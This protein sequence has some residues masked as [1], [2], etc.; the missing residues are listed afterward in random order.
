[1]LISLL[2]TLLAAELVLRVAWV[3]P[4]TLSTQ[5]TGRHPVYVWALRPGISGRHVNNEFDYAFRHTRQGLR[6]TEILT[7]DRDT[8]R[9]RRILMLG[10]SFTYGVGSGEDEHFA[11]LL[12]QSMPDVQLINAGVS[13]Y[14]QRQQLAVLNQ[15]GP[16]LQ[17]DLVVLNFFWNDLEENVKH[18][19]PAWRRAADGSV[20]RTDV[21]VSADFDPLALRTDSA[22]EPDAGPWLKR[23]YLYLLV[24]EGLR[25]FR[26]RLFGNSKRDI[27]TAAQMD[28][29]WELTTE[30]LAMLRDK[31][32]ASGAP[33]VIIGLPDHMLVD[34]QRAN[35]KG[36]NPLNVEIQARLAEV[37]AELGIPYFD[38]LPGL[39]KLQAENPELFYYVIDRHLTPAGNV[40]VANL[41]RPFLLDSLALAAAGEDFETITSGR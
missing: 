37:T 17:P 1:M 32:R 23:A 20:E 22:A 2:V 40:A 8:A 9:S 16:V 33:F 12:Q 35:T 28:A 21:Q 14:S 39:Q 29:A 15:L 11:H 18:A 25:G 13:G 10:D 19:E 26:K 41:A 5:Q 31:S 7:A 30:L 4:S 6:G 34:P 36:M 27:E 24:K 3:P 38:L